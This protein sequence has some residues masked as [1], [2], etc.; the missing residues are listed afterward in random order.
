M[1]GLYSRFVGK[2]SL[3][4]DIGAYVGVKTQMMLDIGVSKVIAV[5]PYPRS[6]VK[7]REKF[8][9]DLR[10]EIV[11]KG[12]AAIPGTMT[13]SYCR[14]KTLCTFS[15]KY[16]TGRFKGRDY[17][18]KVEVEM[19]TLDA[20][21]EQFGVPAFCKIDVEGFERQVLT[22]LSRALPALCYEY[23]IEFEDEALAC[24]ELL[25]SLGDYEFNFGEA[26]E[27]KF[28]FPRW[29]TN[30]KKFL[31]K[32]RQVPSTSHSKLLWGDIYARL[33]KGQR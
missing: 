26:Q 31:K 11:P 10:V 17:S 27:D 30:T 22:G 29:F 9:D 20:L 1:Q 8:G 3:F 25:K 24:T 33:K 14:S 6:V 18:G 21:V 7:L 2:R 4:F 15:E 12:L 5:E 28:V 23:A 19:T 16:K 13:L 32:V